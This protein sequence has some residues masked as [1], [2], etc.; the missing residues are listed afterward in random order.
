MITC[1]CD[2]D[3]FVA[4]ATS[5]NKLLQRTLHIEEDDHFSHW[6]FLQVLLIK[7]PT[8][9][10]AAKACG[11]LQIVRGAL[12]GL[13]QYN[14]YATT[15]VGRSLVGWQQLYARAEGPRVLFATKIQYLKKGPT[16]ALM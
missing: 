8:T 6:F 12:R 15:K 11:V 7:R 1:T 10:R 16:F 5:L 2:H 4:Y 14:T 9:R 13:D 3:C